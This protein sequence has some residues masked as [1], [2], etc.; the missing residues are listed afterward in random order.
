MRAIPRILPSADFSFHHAQ[1]VTVFEP[2][3]GQRNVLT[4][5]HRNH[6]GDCFVGIPLL[7]LRIFSKNEA[8]PTK[9]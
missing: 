1:P 8:R 9:C 2:F 3:H 7:R 6:S 5:Q 4:V